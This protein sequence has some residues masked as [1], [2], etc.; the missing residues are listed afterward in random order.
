[1]IAQSKCG[2]RTEY[3]SVVAIARV[4]VVWVNV[5][6]VAVQMSL[7]HYNRAQGILIRSLDGHAHWVTTLSLNTDA[8]LRTGAFDRH[9]S[10]PDGASDDPKVGTKHRVIWIKV[11]VQSMF[12]FDSSC[13]RQGVVKTGIDCVR[14]LFDPPQPKLLPKPSIQQFWQVDQSFWC[15]VL[16]ISRCS[17]GIQ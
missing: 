5:D 9:G 6:V 16:M 4:F 7:C 3:V 10:L 14:V 12:S 17:C 2:I 1:M 11:V 15:R 13:L 8:V